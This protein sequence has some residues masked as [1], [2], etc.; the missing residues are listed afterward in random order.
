[1]ELDPVTILKLPL[2]LLLVLKKF[3]MIIKQLL[4]MRIVIHTYPKVELLILDALLTD[5]DVLTI[6]E[7]V[8]ASLVPSIN[9][10]NLQLQMALVKLRPQEVF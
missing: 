2:Q 1:M 7:P 6:L 8:Q 9:V 3:V 4:Q 5:K 10:A